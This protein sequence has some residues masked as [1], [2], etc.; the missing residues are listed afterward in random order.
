MGH[1]FQTR[2]GVQS[3]NISQITKHIVTQPWHL[4]NQVHSQ[5][6]CMSASRKSVKYTRITLG[7][8]QFVHTMEINISLFHATAIITPFL[9]PLSNH[10]RIHI[11]SLHT[12]RLWPGLKMWS[13]FWYPNIGQ[14][15]QWRVQEDH[16][17]RLEGKLPTCPKEH[18]FSQCICM[19]KSYLFEI[20]SGIAQD[21]P[22]KCGIFY[23]RKQIWL[24]ISCNNQHLNPLFMHGNIL[25]VRVATIMHPL[26]PLDPLDPLVV[27]SSFTR[28]L[29]PEIPG[30]SMERMAGT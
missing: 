5:S 7:D 13:T 15:I 23:F 14:W 29:E 20:L 6:N 26:D 10:K 4:K 27:K 19:F 22:Q 24:L 18:S 3:K 17:R 2:Q 28:K 9:S 25:M 30:I 21:F 1:L 11:D 16:E 8:Y 12:M